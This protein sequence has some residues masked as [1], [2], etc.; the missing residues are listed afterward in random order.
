M[1]NAFTVTS[2]AWM[3]DIVGTSEIVLERHFKEDDSDL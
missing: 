1:K 2:H 3:M